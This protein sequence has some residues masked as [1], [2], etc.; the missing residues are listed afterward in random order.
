MVGG[1]DLCLSVVLV[2]SDTDI[3]EGS[4]VDFDVD[5]TGAL[6]PT[7]IRWTLGDGTVVDDQ[8]TVRHTYVDNGR[9]DVEVT[10]D[11]GRGEVTATTTV[12]VRNVAPTF[13]LQAPTVGAVGLLY[14]LPL[15][16]IVDPGDDQY[17]VEV[18]WGDGTVQTF[19]ALGRELS[20]SHTYSATSTFVGTVRVTDDDGDAASVQFSVE[21]IDEPAG[22]AKLRLPAWVPHGELVVGE[23][24]IATNVAESIERRLVSGPEGMS[25]DDDGLLRW[26]PEPHQVGVHEVVVA[27]ELRGEVVTSATA[28]IQVS[29]LQLL[30][31]AVIGPAGGTLLVSGSSDLAGSRVVIPPG[32]LDQ[33]VEIGLALLLAAPPTDT[34][35][36][37]VS[38]AFELLPSGLNFGVPVTLEVPVANVANPAVVNYLNGAALDGPS[39]DHWATLPTTSDVG[40]TLARA[41]LSHFSTYRVVSRGP[42]FRVFESE[43]FSIHYRATGVHVPVDGYDD[44][45][46]PPSAHLAGVPRYITALNHYLEESRRHFVQGGYDIPSQ[47]VVE[48]KRM[49]E[50]DS[51]GAAYGRGYFPEVVINSRMD[52]DPIVA[53]EELRF[54]AAHEL[55]HVVQLRKFDLGIPVFGA[56]LRSTLHN[57]GWLFET[58]ATFMGLEVFPHDPRIPFEHYRDGVLATDELQQE[59]YKHFVLFSFLKRRFDGDLIAKM[60][61]GVA[62]DMTT[63]VLSARQYIYGELEEDIWHD[64]ALGFHLFATDDWVAQIETMKGPTQVRRT[65]NSPT[66]TNCQPSG[67]GTPPPTLKGTH[68]SVQVF[69]DDL[70]PNIPALRFCFSR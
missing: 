14:R 12:D 10:V 47:V 40:A 15:V 11:D 23:L 2:V 38:P 13:Q 69:V 58:T 48:V 32:A 63:L 66:S 70:V 59:S 54:T 64:F 4:A 3:D 41:E 46:V 44:P 52:S 45:N 27:V 7:T 25:M 49:R 17:T 57:A 22:T 19:A 35:D 28:T 31:S 30:A 29:D 34:D 8:A 42:G 5:V 36:T 53:I 68:P 61:R 60:F 18:N 65:M 6:G 33:D 55:F 62:P 16:P 56:G 20:L 39:E 26:V 1:G 9:F 43:N 50:P 24:T 51:R 37:P 67:K 21:I